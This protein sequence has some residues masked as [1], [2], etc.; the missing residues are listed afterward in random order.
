MRVAMLVIGLILM[1][2]G[3]AAWFG[4][5]EY[6]HDKEVA[7]IGSISATVSENKTVPQWAAGLAALIGLGLVA[8]GAMRKR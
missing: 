3:I 8:A 6:P 2:G 5:I 4:K 1:V 7:K